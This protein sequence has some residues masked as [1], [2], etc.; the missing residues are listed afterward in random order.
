MSTL[1]DQQGRRSW[2]TPAGAVVALWVLAAAAVTW[3]AAL[4]V[5][6]ADP[7]GQLIS[8]L[9]ALG[10]ALAAASGTRARPRLEAGPDG[11]TIRRLTWTR[12][13]PWARVDDVRV[14]RTRRF[15]RDS[16]LLEL[17]LRDV[18]GTERLVVLGRPELGEDPEDVAEV[19]QDL[20]PRR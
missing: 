14:L 8:G 1:G 16:A 7:A 15:G 13:A 12:H 10:L 6:G 9:A 20:R 18:D 2:S 17:D 4:V 11:V 5:T 3:L 19:L